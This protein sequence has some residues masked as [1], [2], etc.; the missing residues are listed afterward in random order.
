M[1]RAIRYRN[2]KFLFMGIIAGLLIVFYLSA[3]ISFIFAIIGLAIVVEILIYMEYSARCMANNIAAILPLE[4][5]FYEDGLIEYG[6][7]GRTEVVYKSLSR[8]KMSKHLFTL[9]SRKDDVVIVIP[10]C[11]IDR[12]SDVL[13]QKLQRLV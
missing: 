1:G 3:I 13:M 6:S 11:L 10:R 8:V 5:D 12:D 4:Y 2:S 9:V 7:R